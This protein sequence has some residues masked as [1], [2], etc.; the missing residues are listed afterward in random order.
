MEEY[1]AGLLGNLK[2]HFERDATSVQSLVDS[3]VDLWLDGYGQAIPNK[4]V[5]IYYKGAVM[6]LGL[7]LLIRQKFTH[8]KSIRE[9][10]LLMNEQFG[11]IKKGYTLE[12]F[13]HVCSIVFEDDLSSW[14]AIWMESNSDVRFELKRLLAFVG[15]DL[16]WEEDKFAL[17]IVDELLFL[18]Y[19]KA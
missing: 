12:D 17:E 18:A 1:V 5:S 3:S 13:Y 11:G 7:D 14:F 15:L 10:M 2:L 9:V 6:A 16:H 19:R 4:R 8:S